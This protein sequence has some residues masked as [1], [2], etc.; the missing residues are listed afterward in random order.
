MYDTEA[1]TC[2]FI[3]KLPV[4]AGQT[5]STPDKAATIIVDVWKDASLID[6]YLNDDTSRLFAEALTAPLSE[7]EFYTESAQSVADYL[8][9]SPDLFQK[10]ISRIPERAPFMPIDETLSCG[11]SGDATAFVMQAKQE[12]VAFALWI[13]LA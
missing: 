1:D 5:S 13:P 6:K 3:A 4:T 11:F 10:C 2:Y 12:Q 7:K 9:K 8:L